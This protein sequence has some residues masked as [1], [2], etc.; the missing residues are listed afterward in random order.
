MPQPRFAPEHHHLDA[1]RLLRTILLQRYGLVPE[2]TDMA[3]IK[4]VGGPRGAR[5]P[6]HEAVHL[7]LH[8][9]SQARVGKG[10]Q[11][12]VSEYQHLFGLNPKVIC[13]RFAPVPS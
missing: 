3:K 1:P 5:R 2:G 11:S 8:R 7:V 12:R 4:K 6:G 10:T 13:S 9:D